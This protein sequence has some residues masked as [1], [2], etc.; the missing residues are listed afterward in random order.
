MHDVPLLHLSNV[1]ACCLAITK[2]SLKEYNMHTCTERNMRV[3]VTEFHYISGNVLG[4]THIY[5]EA[6]L[7]AMK[8]VSC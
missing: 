6:G 5:F 3:V 7:E 4:I 2:M 1:P 8:I